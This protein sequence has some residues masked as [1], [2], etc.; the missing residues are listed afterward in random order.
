MRRVS[1]FALATML[2]L[3]GVASAGEN[4]VTKVTA[5]ADGGRR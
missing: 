5:R 4:V 3:A 2:V 1:L